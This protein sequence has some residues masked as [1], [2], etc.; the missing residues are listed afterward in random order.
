M[1][2]KVPCSVDGMYYDTFI[3]G[4]QTIGGASEYVS[5]LDNTDAI[6]KMEVIG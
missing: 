1:E 4:G 5:K 6:Q 3:E 2:V